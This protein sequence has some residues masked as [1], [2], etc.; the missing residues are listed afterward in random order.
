MRISHNLISIVVNNFQCFNLSVIEDT[1]RNLGFLQ[2]L[3]KRKHQNDVYYATKEKFE[4]DVEKTSVLCMAQLKNGMVAAAGANKI[5]YSFSP[6]DLDKLYKNDTPEILTSL[7]GLRNGSLISGAENC[8]IRLWDLKQGGEIKLLY[9]K[10]AED[11]TVTELLEIKDGVVAIV[12]ADMNI[13][14]LLPNGKV[15]RFPIQNR[16]KNLLFSYNSLFFLLED[17]TFLVSEFDIK[18]ARLVNYVESGPDP[19]TTE[20]YTNMFIIRGFQVGHVIRAASEKEYEIRQFDSS[21]IDEWKKHEKVSLKKFNLYLEDGVIYVL[22]FANKL[23]KQVGSIELDSEIKS[24]L[25]LKDGRVI[26]SLCDGSLV[27]LN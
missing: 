5:L 15:L 19:Y 22:D 18:Q 21:F 25:E 13:R 1:T 24:F 20:I 6:R 23:D 26:V 16:I 10:K 27:F 3:L 8:I 14:F 12:C 9:K 7:L 11:K 2:T 4:I 17:D